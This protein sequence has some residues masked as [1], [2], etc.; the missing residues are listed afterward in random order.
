MKDKSLQT[1]PISFEVTGQIDSRFTFVKIYL[2]HL[3]LNLNGSIFTKEIVEKCWDTL[4][5]TP[6]LGYIQVDENEN[7]IGKCFP[8]ISNR[9]GHKDEHTHHV[10]YIKSDRF[11]IRTPNPDAQHVIANFNKD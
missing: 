11:K 9:S 6:I 4:A 8:A 2:M 3:G 1:I 5:L 7:M 10:T